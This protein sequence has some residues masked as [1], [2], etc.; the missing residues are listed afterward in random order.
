MKF[1]NIFLSIYKKYFSDFIA[2]PIKFFSIQQIIKN[3]RN[4]GES[5]VSPLE[6]SQMA[7]LLV[8]YQILMPFKPI[9]IIACSPENHMT[10]NGQKMM[11][12][13]PNGMAQ[14]FLVVAFF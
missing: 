12:W 2:S 5:L 4:S 10:L 14:L 1:K 13:N 7:I 8:S 11:P 3:V 9:V 6:I